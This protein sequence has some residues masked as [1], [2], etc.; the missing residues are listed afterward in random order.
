MQDIF[1]PALTSLGPQSMSTYMWHK[2]VSAFLQCRFES[3]IF[4]IFLTYMLH[5]LTCSHSSLTK[6]KSRSVKIQNLFQNLVQPHLFFCYEK[7]YFSLYHLFCLFLYFLTLTTFLNW[8][9]TAVKLVLWG[10]L[11]GGVFFKPL[12]FF[13]TLSLALHIPKF[14][15][16]PIR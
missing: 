15:N 6:T 10:F 8:Y 5:T 7:Y 4:T 2:Y 3:Y 16:K 13:S 12:T 1:H 9:Y 11:V 14:L